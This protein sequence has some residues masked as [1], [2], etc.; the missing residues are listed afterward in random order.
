SEEDFNNRPEF[1]DAEI[2]RT[3][4]ASVVLQM[5]HLRLG[6]IEDFP[7]VD[8]PDRRLIN[9]GYKLLEELGAV[10]SQRQITELGRQMARIPADPRIAR[11]LLESARLGCLREILVIASALGIPD[12]RER[13][14]D[15]QQ[16]ADERHGAWKDK[17]S[18]F[19]SLVNV[20]NYF[21]SEEHT[22]ELQ[23]REN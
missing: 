3:N 23:S 18:D 10:D 11:M 15:R 1:T 17:D 13:P 4:L 9:D 14:L 8:A 12:P 6:N 5:L 20:W 2:L 16:Q 7:F 22:S 21:R 19:L